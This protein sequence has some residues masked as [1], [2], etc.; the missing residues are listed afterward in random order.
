MVGD[1]N[2]RRR[3]RLIRGLGNVELGCCLLVMSDDMRC[4]ATVLHLIFISS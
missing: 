1:G 4:V 2:I 3:K